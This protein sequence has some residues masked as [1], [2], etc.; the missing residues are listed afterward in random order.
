VF[1]ATGLTGRIAFKAERASLSPTLDAKQ[2]RGTARLGPSEVV[3]EDVDGELAKGRLAGRLAFGS[4]A[5]G[6]VALAKVDLSGAEMAAVYPGAGRPPIS[7]RLTLRAD[8]EGA[9]LSPAAFMGSLSGSGAIELDEAQFANLSP[10][11]FDA[12]IRAVDL[13][14]PA[15]ASRIRDFVATALDSAGLKVARASAAIKISAGQ[16]RL[17]DVTTQ[18][19]GVDVVLA[20]ALDLTSATLDA[21]VTMSGRQTIGGTDHPTVLVALKGAL[22]TPQ[23]SIDA[24]LLASWLALRSV[25]QQAKQ[26][27]QLERAQSEAH[28]QAEREAS[29]RAQRELAEPS[30][31][32]PVAPMD[33]PGTIPATAS[34]PNAGINPGAA[35]PVSAAATSGIS[36]GNEAP[37]LPPPVDVGAS[38]RPKAVPQIDDGAAPAQAR[39]PASRYQAPKP[40]TRRPGP[41]LDLLGGSYR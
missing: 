35:S 29:Q 25:D 7:G 32:I 5:D 37:P 2:L 6:L 16:V 14:I 21:N 20:A 9:G 12:V 39:P 1:I 17:T 33:D 4:N 36:P 24:N 28:E 40:T 38:P 31:T 11:V 27:E 18:A 3:F 15:D 10:R 41:P 23:R 22:P 34:V 26:L 8:V 13:G 19:D 30:P